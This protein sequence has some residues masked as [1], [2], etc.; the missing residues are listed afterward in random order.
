MQV[1][2]AVLH[3]LIHSGLTV[4]EFIR[5]SPALRQQEFT[6]E[7]VSFVA[8]V[9]RTGGGI[10]VPLRNRDR[11]AVLDTEKAAATA[12]RPI[13]VASCHTG[14]EE[15]DRAHVAPKAR[16]NRTSKRPRGCTTSPARSKT[17]ATSAKRSRSPEIQ[18]QTESVRA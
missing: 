14:S 1:L 9:L 3:E 12:E 5:S 15:D 4:P 13:S 17:A 8:H 7:G 18:Q 16:N 10:K 6:D 11:G 2:A